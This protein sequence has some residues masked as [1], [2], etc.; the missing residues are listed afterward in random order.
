MLATVTL[1]H[2]DGSLHDLH[3]GDIIGRLWS[4]AL[5]LDDAGVSEAHALVSLRGAELKLLS[6]RGL[7]AVGGEPVRSLTLAVGQRIAITRTL[8]VEVVAVQV[9][10]T[11]LALTGGDLPTLPLE[12]VCSLVAE[13]LLRLVPR[14][15]A[16]LPLATFWFTGEGWRVRLPDGSVDHLEPG[17]TL[18]TPRGEVRALALGLSRGTGASTVARGRHSSRLVVECHYDTVHL[19]R[20]GHPTLTLSGQMAVLVS[21]LAALST[22]VDWGAAAG[23]IWPD[24]PDRSVLRRRWDVLLARLRRKLR[25][26]GVRADLVKPDGSGNYSLVLLPGDRVDDQS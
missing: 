26:H 25:E 20:E 15:A 14:R 6:L 7:F 23:L 17:W 5:R 2:P 18:P 21:E 4:A 22:A 16:A 13:P 9:P 1:R 8:E 12:G 10:H 3:H 24:V 19:H 11:V